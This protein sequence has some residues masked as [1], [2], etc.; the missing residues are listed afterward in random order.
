MNDTNSARLDQENREV[1]NSELEEEDEEDEEQEI[2][3]VEMHS[4]RGAHGSTTV[5]AAL[6]VVIIVLVREQWPGRVGASAPASRPRRAAEGEARTP[7]GRRI[8]RSDNPLAIGKM[9]I[10]LLLMPFTIVPPP[11]PPIAELQTKKLVGGSP[12]TS[13]DTSSNIRVS[14]RHTVSCVATKA[15]ACLHFNRLRATSPPMVPR[16]EGEIHLH[17][18]GAKVLPGGPPAQFPYRGVVLQQSPL[19]CLCLRLVGRLVDVEARDGALMAP[20]V[21]LSENAPD[22]LKGAMVWRPMSGNTTELLLAHEPT[23]PG[24]RG[25]KEIAVL[26]AKGQHINLSQSVRA[27]TT[28]LNTTAIDLHTHTY[29]CLAGPTNATITTD[30]HAQVSR[31][32][33]HTHTAQQGTGGGH[34][35]NVPTERRS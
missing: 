20:F 13:R 14:W 21:A 18:Q 17:N 30:P 32:E 1:V 24:D 23:T 5:P 27:A 2:L 7:G 4:D 16:S 9:S 19:H 12:A 10:T 34:P 31:R 26:L 28:R 29:T 8:A 6:V 33:A 35:R 25:P 22:G 11:D 3:D 15:S